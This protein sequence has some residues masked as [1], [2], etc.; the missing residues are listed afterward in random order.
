MDLPGNDQCCG[1]AGLYFLR[2]PDLAKAL[3]DDKVEALHAGAPD[4]VATTNFGCGRWIQEGLHASDT[5]PE[6]LHP[7]VLVARLLES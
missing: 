1:G 5:H 4:Y 7:V 3:R 2:E 6:V